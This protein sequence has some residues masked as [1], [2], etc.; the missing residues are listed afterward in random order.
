[1]LDTE[2][3]DDNLLIYMAHEDYSCGTA[4]WEQGR[5]QLSVMR[6]VASPKLKLVVDSHL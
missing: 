4:V 2:M 5:E 6:F 1:M 3:C